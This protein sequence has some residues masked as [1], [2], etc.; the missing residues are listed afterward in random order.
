MRGDA[1]WPVF[2]GFVFMCMGL[3]LAAGARRHAR[4]ARE[5]SEQAGAPA[6]EGFLLGMYRLG[7]GLFAAAGAACLAGALAAPRWLAA[8]ARTPRLSPSGAA[9]AGALF[10]SGGTLFCALKAA[11][12]LRDRRW[13]RILDEPRPRPPLSERFC[14]ALE[15]LMAL[16]FVAFG[17]YLLA[18]GGRTVPA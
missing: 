4:S 2:S 18:A 8:L 3:H 10:V 13:S 5:W 15:A 9:L 12:A 6:S 16:A 17:L 11:A 1:A 14:R 7:G